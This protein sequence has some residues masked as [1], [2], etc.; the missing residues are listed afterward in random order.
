MQSKLNLTSHWIGLSRISPELKQNKQD[1][2]W[3]KASRIPICVDPK[4]ELSLRVDS[5]NKCCL[6]YYSCSFGYIKKQVVFSLLFL[7]FRLYQETSVVFFTILVLAVLSRNKCG[8]LYH[9]CN[10]GLS[11]NK[12][13]LLYYS[14]SCG[15]IKKPVWSS[16]L[17][18]FLQCCQEN[19]C[20]LL[21][22]SCSCDSIKKTSVVFSTI[23][24][25]VVL[26]RKKVW[27]SLQFLFLWFYQ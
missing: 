2:R 17:F 27:S 23:L 16:L 21:Y 18:L 12:W 24:V 14:C 8:L 25:L 15:S 10:C 5:R 26:S 7:F 4:Y 19:K 9:S 1:P 20:G 3:L 22:H 13:W 6:L 11:R